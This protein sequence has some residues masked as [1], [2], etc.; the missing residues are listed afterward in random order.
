MHE[1]RWR[2][3]VEATG[4]GT[5]EVDG[6]TGRHAWSPEFRAI[7]GLPPDVEPST[8][9]FAD[10]IHP[11]DSAWV[12]RAY[13]AAFRPEGDGSYEAEFRIRRADTGE[14]RW[15]LARGR[16][17]FGDRRQVVRGMGLLLDTTARRSAERALVESEERFRLAVA[18]FQGAVFETDLRTGHAYRSP[19]AYEMLGV[20]E[21]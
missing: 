8:A 4:L 19:R 12:N 13:A 17:A 21:A 20:D 9:L 18:S 6:A 16:I 2:L 1:E 3:A 7:C 5:W 14:E 11:D 10:L 15:V